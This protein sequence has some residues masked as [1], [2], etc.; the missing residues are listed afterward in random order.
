MVRQML[1][2][3]SFAFWGG[4]GCTW[5]CLESLPGEGESTQEERK[6]DKGNG[7]KSII[8]TTLKLWKILV[9]S[10]RIIKA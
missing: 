10:P 3:V 6:A 8:H 2:I 5:E 9:L 1:N 4:L 7:G